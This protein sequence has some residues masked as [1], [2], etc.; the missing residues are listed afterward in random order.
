MS[1]YVVA[2]S[3]IED[4][5]KLGEYVGKALPTIQANGGRVLAFDESP[6]VIEGQNPLP[7]TVIVEFPSLEVFRAWY[8]SED[9]QA[10]L[11]LRLESAPGT[12]I[13]ANGLG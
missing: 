6:E 7:R 11:P 3:R 4:P 10:I 8:D 13:V 5:E 1:V 9:Y 2:Q 12:L